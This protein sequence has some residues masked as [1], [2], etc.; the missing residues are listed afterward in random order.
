[1]GWIVTCMSKIKK[2]EALWKLYVT[3]GDNSGVDRMII[4]KV[5]R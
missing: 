3:G 2:H 1:M 4:L 5:F